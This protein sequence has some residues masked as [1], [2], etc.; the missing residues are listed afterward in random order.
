MWKSVFTQLF[1]MLST[2][3][4]G[5]V[6]FLSII[7][8]VILSAIGYPKEV[9]NFIFWMIVIDLCTKHYSIIVIHYKRFNLSNYINGWRDRFLT[10]RGMKDGLGVKALLYIPILYIAHKLSVIPEVVFGSAMSSILYSLLLIIEI[11]SVLENLSDAGHTEVRPLVKL[12]RKKKDE[13]LNEDK[14]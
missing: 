5:T 4:H 8:G 3:F 11:I 10:S 9:L 14:K 6:V 2:M 7:L 12:F 13:L 1:E